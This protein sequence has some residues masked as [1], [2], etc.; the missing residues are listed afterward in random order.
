MNRRN[1]LK[2][3]AQA[4]LVG[5]AALVSPTLPVSMRLDAS[6]A[7]VQT[8]A[9]MRK[10]RGTPDGRILESFDGGKTWRPTAN[11]GRHC[12][13]LAILERQGQLYTQVGIQ[14]YSFFLSSPDGRV[15]RTAGWVPA[16]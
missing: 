15:W 9:L 5:A 16:A 10:F 11:F 4:S 2:G 12:S 14:G 3:V 1:F 7:F 13:I 6:P 8:D